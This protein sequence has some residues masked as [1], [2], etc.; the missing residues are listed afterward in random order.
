MPSK[1]SQRVRCDHSV[2]QGPAWALE[3]TG[4][5]S[6]LGKAVLKSVFPLLS[7]ECVHRFKSHF[8]VGLQL[9]NH[10]YPLVLCTSVVSNHRSV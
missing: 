10:S 1:T 2:T 8:L 7:T 5:H 3:G 9:L 4:A 6:A